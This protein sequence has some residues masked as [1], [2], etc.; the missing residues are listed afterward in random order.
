M[1]RAGFFR[2][3]WGGNKG[4]QGKTAHGP[5]YGGCGGVPPYIKGGARP[6][7]RKTDPKTVAPTRLEEKKPGTVPK[8]PEKRKKPLDY[9]PHLLYNVFVLRETEKQRQG[10]KRAAAKP[11]ILVFNNRH[12]TQPLTNVDEDRGC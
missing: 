2:P 11:N 4:C 10:T 9:S 8:N 5:F 7:P 6:R 3:G 12:S 1:H